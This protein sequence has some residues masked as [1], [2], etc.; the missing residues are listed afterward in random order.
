MSFFIRRRRAS[1]I[2]LVLAVLAMVAVLAMT[3]AMLARLDS[4]VGRNYGDDLT[5]EGKIGDHGVEYF[6]AILSGSAERLAGLAPNYSAY[7]AVDN[8]HRWLAGIR[9]DAGAP[10]TYS[11]CLSFRERDDWPTTPAEGFQFFGEFNVT[12]AG[13][14]FTGA[15]GS[16][17]N[18]DGITDGPN[19][20]FNGRYMTGAGF[21]YT[22]HGFEIT[23]DPQGREHV[24]CAGIILD[25]GSRLNVNVIGNTSGLGES[26]GFADGWG[27]DEISLTPLGLDATA[28]LAANPSWF[29]PYFADW[30]ASVRTTGG[31]LEYLLV[32]G[33]PPAGASS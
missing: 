9:F 32:R 27:A 30:P 21:D 25:L 26:H 1:A 19:W 8:N 14:A 3:F 10:A 12:G 29:P 24:E 7:E 20:G 11:Q 33:G 15:S 5:T 28:L 23:L 4:R 31:L 16:D 6:S 13:T 2:L 22:A 18:Q 17:I